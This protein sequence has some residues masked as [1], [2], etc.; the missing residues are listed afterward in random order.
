MKLVFG[1]IV[2]AKIFTLALFTKFILHTL[3]KYVLSQVYT[4]SKKRSVFGKIVWTD[5]DVPA[6][7]L[8]RSYSSQKAPT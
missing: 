1:E 3:Q 6:H 7:W 2:S 4:N 8:G 5:S